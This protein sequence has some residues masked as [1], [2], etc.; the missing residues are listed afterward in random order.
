[1]ILAAGRGERMRPLTDTIPKALLRARGKTLIEHHLEALAR[2]GINEVVI[3]LAWLGDQIRDFVGNGSGWAMQVEYSNEGDAALETGGGI[4]RALDLLGDDP[5]WVVNGDIYC[6]YDFPPIELPAEDLAYLLL[7]PNPAHH[8][9]GDFGLS[10]GRVLETG[11]PRLTY[12][13][14]AVLRPELFTGCT[15]GR[16]PLAPLLSSAIQAG[17]VAGRQFDGIWTDVGT[18]E[19]LAALQRS[20]Q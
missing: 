2:A 16:F 12:S 17:R 11:V 4:F 9:K 15:A 8:V 18:P 14:I 19:R 13:G 1:M 5:F 7:V 20:R 10:A 3:N 6:E